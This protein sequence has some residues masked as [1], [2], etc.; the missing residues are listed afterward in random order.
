MI[1]IDYYGHELL[2]GHEAQVLMQ[3]KHKGRMFFIYGRKVR[4][5]YE[6]WGAPRV[7]L[8]KSLIK[9]K[10]IICYQTSK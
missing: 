10:E 7:V 9:L 2:K 6:Q 5:R 3:Y 4:D 1:R 8:K